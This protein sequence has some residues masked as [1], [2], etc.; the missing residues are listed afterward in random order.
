MLSTYKTGDI[1]IGLK[2]F[3][4]IKSGNTVILQ[5]PSNNRLIIKRI[6]EIRGNEYFVIGDNQKESTDSREFGWIKRN[7][8]VAKVVYKIQ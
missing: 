6:K 8:V 3:K 1:V 5:S 4:N 7:L 2:L